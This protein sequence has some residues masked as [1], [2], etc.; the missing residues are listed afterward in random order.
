M[1]TREVVGRVWE[2]VPQEQRKKPRQREESVRYL[3]CPSRTL[4][5]RWRRVPKRN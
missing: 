4:K 5:E 2:D 3:G 1:G